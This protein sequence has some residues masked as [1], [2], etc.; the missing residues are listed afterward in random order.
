[1][2]NEHG[3]APKPKNWMVESILATLLCCLP[4]GIAGIVNAS[5]VNSLYEAGD[6]VGAQEASQKAAKWTKIA[7][8]SGFIFLLLYAGFWGYMISQGMGDELGF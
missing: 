1:M 3:L 7:A 6:L 5:K 4:F 2:E 8:I